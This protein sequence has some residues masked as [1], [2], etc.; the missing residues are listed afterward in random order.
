MYFP[1][2]K[3]GTILESRQVSYAVKSLD[4]TFGCRVSG[5][6]LVLVLVG[7]LLGDITG[8]GILLDTFC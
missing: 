2:L 4:D 5:Q 6:V 3:Q 7:L 8:Q 1:I